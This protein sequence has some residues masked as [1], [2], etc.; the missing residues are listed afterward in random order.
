MIKIKEKII[1]KIINKRDKYLFKVFSYILKKY[2][3]S[4]YYKDCMEILTKRNYNDN[5]EYIFKTKNSCDSL[6][7]MKALDNRIKGSNICIDIAANIGIISIWMPKNSSQVYSLEPENNNRIRFCENIKVNNISNI[8]II[9]LAVSNRVGWGELNIFESYGHHSLGR[10]NTTKFVRKERVEIT[11]LDNFCKERNIDFIDCLKID[12]EGFELE[13]LDGTM[14]LIQNNRI[15][16]IILEISKFL[17][18]KFKK[19]T[20]EIFHILS[21]NNYTIYNLKHEKLNRDYLRN[22]IQEDIYAVLEIENTKV[23]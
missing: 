19:N 5:F 18:T 14:E 20:N 22:I 21:S 4:F 12:V 3:V 1:K 13:V 17:F 15:K 10:V 6:P 23:R 11:T 16:F 7:M 2:D 8:E 9:P